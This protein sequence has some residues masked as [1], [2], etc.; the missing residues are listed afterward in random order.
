MTL[1]TL[2]KLAEF[3]KPCPKLYVASAAH[4]PDDCYGILY[5]RPEEMKNW[6]NEGKG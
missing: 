5:V 1:E 2:E 4:L 3:S 6:K